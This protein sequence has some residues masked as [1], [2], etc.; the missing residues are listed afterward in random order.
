METWAWCVKCKTTTHLKPRALRA[1][2]LTRVS[3]PPPV[4]IP[5][6]IMESL[7]G[8]VAL[9]SR[10]AAEFSVTLEKSQSRA[11]LRSESRRLYDVDWAKSECSARASA[12]EYDPPTVRDSRPSTRRAGST[13]VHGAVLMLGRRQRACSTCLEKR[14][15]LWEERDG[16]SLRMCSCAETQPRA[17]IARIPVANSTGV[18][19]TNSSTAAV[20]ASACTAAT[21]GTFKAIVDHGRGVGMDVKN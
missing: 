2:L 1:R 13:L 18:S 12:E 3:W 6:V 20:V 15:V 14:M 16:P 11:P 8:A 10:T 5:Q 17:N 7:R 19:T 9:C 21:V 4:T